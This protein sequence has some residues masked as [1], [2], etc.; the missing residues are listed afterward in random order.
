MPL[1]LHNLSS[2]RATVRVD[3]GDDGDVSIVYRPGN[4]TEKLIR[5]VQGMPDGSAAAQADAL[6]SLAANNSLLRHLIVS[7]DLEWD[8]VPVP[9]TAEAIAEVPADICGHLLRAIVED[10]QLHPMTGMS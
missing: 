2:N 9:V 3:F 10:M 6:T 5:D 7:W 8:G 1:N 4:V